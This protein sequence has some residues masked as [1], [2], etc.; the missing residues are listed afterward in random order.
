[1]NSDNQDKEFK[2]KYLKYKN[3]YLEL[4]NIIGG[5]RIMIGSLIY[6]QQTNKYIGKVTKNLPSLIKIEKFIIGKPKDIQYLR[7]VDQ[8]KTWYVKKDSRVI[9]ENPVIKESNDIK[10]ARDD[11]ARAIRNREL[12]FKYS[13]ELMKSIKSYSLGE[14]GELIKEDIKKSD[15]V[16]EEVI[17]A[18]KHFRNLLVKEGVS[19]EEAEDKI[20]EVESEARKVSAPVVEE[21]DRRVREAETRKVSAPVVEERDK[22]VSEALAS[23]NELSKRF[24]AEIAEAKA[25]EAV[26]AARVLVKP[27]VEKEKWVTRGARSDLEYAIRDRDFRAESLRKAREF[28]KNHKPKNEGNSQEERIN[29]ARD[30]RLYQTFIDSSLQELQ[31]ADAKVASA[32][33]HLEDLIAKEAAGK[34]AAA[35][36]RAPTERSVAEKAST[37]KS[38]AE[39][40]VLALERAAAERAAAERAA[41]AKA[42][43]AKAA[44][45]KAA[46]S[47]RVLALPQR[48]GNPVKESYTI[49]AARGDLAEAISLKERREK[50]VEEWREY[51]QNH[52]PKNEGNTIEERINVARELKDQRYTLNVRLAAVEE[53]EGQVIAAR[54]HL[55]KL[56]EQARNM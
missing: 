26:D 36:E 35:T 19:R 13:K 29:I 1:M 12:S 37:E 31:N 2:N 44:T 32:R 30:L 47:A 52:K 10:A 20:L 16:Y 8:N 49:K 25:A 21:G 38:A 53:A 34:K 28:V 3:K 23:A 39:E 33:R 24:K 17:A 4:K 6:D 18:R 46:T 43:T 56:L 15:K 55:E 22:R 54:S 50:L 9:K 41:A 42:A 45:A 7:L 11:F 5:K 14:Q 51:I 48:E 27:S 40:R